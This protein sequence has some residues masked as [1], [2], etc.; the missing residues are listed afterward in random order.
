MKPLERG[1][2]FL[3]RKDRAGLASPHVSSTIKC[4]GKSSS[5]QKAVKGTVYIFIPTHASER[6]GYPVCVC[7]RACASERKYVSRDD[8]VT[9]NGK[10]SWCSWWS[11][12][13]FQFHYKKKKK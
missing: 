12:M 4:K 2:R 7:V 1:D 8:K 6:G 3:T 9:Y 13:N 11:K 5:E 10:L